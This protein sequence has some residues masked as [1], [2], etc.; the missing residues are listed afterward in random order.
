MTTTKQYDYLNRLLSVASVPSASAAVILNYAC[1]SANQRTQRAEADGTY[2][3]YGYDSLGQVTNGVR[4][5]PDSTPVAGQQFGYAFDDIGNRTSAKAGGDQNGAN[6]RSA[7]YSANNLNQYSSRTVPGAVDVMGVAPAA[8]AVSVNSQATYRNGEYFRK[9]LSVG[10]GSTAL[11]TNI[12]VSSP[13]LATVSGNEFVP[14]TPEQFTYD[15]D[16]NLV[17]DGHW[18]YGWDAANRL[19]ALTNRASAAPPQVL[20]FEYDARGRR[21]HKQV[22]N[23][24]NGSGTPVTDLKC[25]YDGWNLIAILRSD[26]SLLNSFLWGLDLSGS[27]QG[28]GG[29]GG[30]LKVGYYGAQTT[31]CFAAF[32]G[33]GNLAGLVNTADGTTVAQYEYGPFG[34]F[35]RATGPMAKANP[36]RFS[37]KYQDD[38]TDLLYYGYRNYNASTGRWVNRDP[39][40]ENG[41][42]NIYGFV[43]NSPVDDVDLLG[44]CDDCKCGPDVSRLVSQTEAS[45]QTAFQ[46]VPKG[47]RRYVACGNILKSVYSSSNWDVNWLIGMS[48]EGVPKCDYC[49]DTVTYNG[50]C[51]KRYALWYFLYGDAAKFCKKKFPNSF[52][53]PIQTLFEGLLIRKPIMHDSM[54]QIMDK[55]EVAAYFYGRYKQLSNQEPTCPAAS[56]EYPK[57]RI[58][59]EDWHWEG[60][61]W[62]K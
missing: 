54:K 56:G 33:N 61:K 25:V 2:W 44:L 62:E 10:N 43:Y 51:F 39:D 9:E 4:H 22:W 58:D 29:V 57:N 50:K 16:G 19:V 11:W 17:S 46:G 49:S 41:G 20:H 18:N 36:F 37:T 35:L 47:W 6:L 5:W 7:N 12:T 26:S 52:G 32:D 8:D 34:E 21:I 31:N 24:S 27:L 28:A 59:T 13:G 42:L 53:D 1:N 48:N 23:N 60:V 30:L 14:Q 15:A 45:V 55:V 38:E 40:D 3:L